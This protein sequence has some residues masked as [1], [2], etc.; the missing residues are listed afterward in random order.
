MGSDV[1]ALARLR[2]A[3]FED[4]AAEAAGLH[5][6]PS[7]TGLQSPRF[8]DSAHERNTPMRLTACRCTCPA[9]TLDALY[10]R[11]PEPRPNSQNNRY[12]PEG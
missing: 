12:H 3:P 9:S 11:Q 10:P 4:P 5:R 7:P 1:M 2:G 8:P 6:A